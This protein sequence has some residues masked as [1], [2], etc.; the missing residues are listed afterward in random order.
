MNKY[1]ICIN[2]VR[3]NLWR[4]QKCWQWHK[5]WCNS[6]DNL[7]VDIFGALPERW[8]IT[9]KKGTKDCLF[10][11][12]SWQKYDFNKRPLL[13]YI[14]VEFKLI[15]NLLALAPAFAMFT[16]SSSNFVC[17]MRGVCSSD[18]KF[19]SPLDCPLCK[20]DREKMRAKL[21]ACSRIACM[22]VNKRHGWRNNE[23]EG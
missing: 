15:T 16:D 8:T 22:K 19:K 12:V 5:R 3:K 21:R 4:F 10:L 7:S 17:V 11:S 20:F 13:I 23:R 18:S 9:K 14:A 1:I 2:A 6:F